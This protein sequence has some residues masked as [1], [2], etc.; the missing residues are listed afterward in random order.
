MR[1]ADKVALITGGGSGIGK[2]SCLIFA[3]EG[4]KV[5][6]VDLKLD[7]AE[8]TADEIRKAGGDAK[9][10]AADVS[11][12]DDAEAMVRFAEESYGKLNVVFNNAGVFHPDD[13]SV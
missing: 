11:K 12:A 9:A 6:V 3:K 7:T 4:A 10:F 5:V 13:D 1:L 2:A 8:A